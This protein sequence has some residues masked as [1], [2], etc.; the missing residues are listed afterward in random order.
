MG[1]LHGKA[2]VRFERL[3]AVDADLRIKTQKW[4]ERLA[5]LAEEAH[6]ER[7]PEAVWTHIRD[8]LPT[9]DPLRPA[10]PADKPRISH[11]WDSLA[12]WRGLAAA[13][14][15]L[16]AF[17]SWSG[18]GVH[19]GLAPE[20]IAVISNARQEPVWV[21]ST[22]SPAGLLRVRTV[23]APGMGP[24][25]VCPLWLQWDGGKEVRRI[26]ILPEE[27]GSS[28]FRIPEN[29]PLDRARLAV[30]VEPAGDL[31]QEGP[32]GRLIYQGNWTRL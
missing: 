5:P 4:E 30:S 12:F 6:P 24:G 31:P 13:A 20:R 22:G 15:L 32:R 27:K 21:L 1:T 25:R 9:S 18:L 8:R 17:V 7:P 11:W 28:T 16:L 26:A 14:L 19:P 10:A 3:L 2:R 23:Q 29:M